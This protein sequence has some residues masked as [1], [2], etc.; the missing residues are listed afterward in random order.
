M[1][2][3]TDIHMCARTQK[4]WRINS[5]QASGGGSYANSAALTYSKQVSSLTSPQPEY[6]SVFFS[7]GELSSGHFHRPPSTGAKLSC[8]CTISY[9]VFFYIH[10]LFASEPRLQSNQASM[11][12]GKAVHISAYG[13]W[14]EEGTQSKGLVT[15]AFMANTRR[16]SVC[17]RGG[18]RNAFGQHL[19]ELCDTDQ[20]ETASSALA[21]EG[22]VRP[23]ESRA[24]E[25]IILARV[26]RSILR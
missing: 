7:S 17:F 6:R 10:E 20:L 2:A 5:S 4:Y 13:G 15:P 23:W 14:G 11:P 1:E 24:E 26:T 19:G 22:A 25:V 3:S 16:K 21:S 12:L 8:A 18:R 9:Y